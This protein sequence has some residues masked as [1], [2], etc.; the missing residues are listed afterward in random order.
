MCGVFAFLT[1]AYYLTSSKAPSRCC[2]E[3]CQSSIA[4]V[5]C[6][7]QAFTG[8]MCDFQRSNLTMDV[9][10]ALPP[11]ISDLGPRISDLG[12]RTSDLGPRTS[13]LGPRTSDLEPRASDLGSRTSD[14]GPRTSDLNIDQHIGPTYRPNIADPT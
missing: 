6:A 9:A 12:P 4:G 13:D 14:L 3:I 7:N 8:G 2:C 10:A 1:L 5:S 11:R